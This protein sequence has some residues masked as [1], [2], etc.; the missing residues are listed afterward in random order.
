M[1]DE[2]E[3]ERV[4]ELVKQNDGYCPCLVQKN[5]DTSRSSL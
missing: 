5:E 4:S 1:K 3:F 2:I